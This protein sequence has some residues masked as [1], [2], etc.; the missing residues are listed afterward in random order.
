[1]VAWGHTKAQLLHCTHFSASHS[2]TMTAT[3]RFSNAA[4]PS[5]NWPFARSAKTETGSVSP[6]MLPTGRM[7]SHTC[8]TSS[9]RPSGA[10]GAGAS[11]A[12][13]QLAGTSIF[14]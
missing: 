10:A 13:A 14:T 5:S 8:F 2:G 9:A 7:I 3:P 1:M 12:S 4:A 6:A 11:E